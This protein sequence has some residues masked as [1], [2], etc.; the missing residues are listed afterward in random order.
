MANIFRGRLQ[1]TEGAYFAKKERTAVG[2]AAE[3]LREAAGA[4][5]ARVAAANAARTAKGP[6]VDILPEVMGHSRVFRV[7]E[8]DAPD[9]RKMLG[10]DAGPG[11]AAGEAARHDRL[12]EAARKGK[13]EGLAYYARKRVEDAAIVAPGLGW[14]ERIRLRWKDMSDRIL[15][16]LFG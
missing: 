15:S 4:N 11:D 1:R 8:T 14:L 3:K 12:K 10:L 13:E 9:I 7:P 5:A 16:A 2:E 6:T